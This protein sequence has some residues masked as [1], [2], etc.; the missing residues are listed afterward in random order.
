MKKV[1]AVLGAAALLSAI[2]IG[3][4]LTRPSTPVT[5]T[6][7]LAINPW[8]GYELLY[9]A[10]K[11]GFFKEEGLNLKLKQFSTLEDVRH[12]IE[13]GAVEGI[14]STTADVV[15]ATIHSGKTIQTVLVPDYS[16]GGDEIIGLDSIRSPKDLKGKSIGVEPKSVGALVLARALAKHHLTWQDVKVL[17][18]DQAAMTP[19][20]QSGQI[21]AAV[22]YPPFSIG[23]MKEVQRAHRI[24]DSSQ[25]PGEIVDVVSF[26]KS[27]LDQ[28]PEVPP[29]LRRVWGKALDY[30]QT[31]PDDAIAIMAQ[32]EGITP[33]EFKEA[34]SGLSLVSVQ[35]QT[36]YLQPAG[37]LESAYAATIATLRT[38][39]DLTRDFAPNESFVRH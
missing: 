2:G 13:N 6:A 23:M 39:G 34:L 28:H 26:D 9:L 29:A 3:Y 15:Q 30:L 19:A 14:C 24:F 22:T 25:I 18:L 35:D 21:Q 5:R 20:L 37:K 33:A 11:K 7:Q 31:H 12:S 10:E 32:R 1:L 36:S 4:S 27:Y 38:T 8:P 16:N 17:Y